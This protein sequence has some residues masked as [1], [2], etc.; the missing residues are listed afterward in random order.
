[1]PAEQQYDALAEQAV[2]ATIFT[3]PE[4][5]DDLHDIIQPSDFFEERNK[6]IFEAAITLQENGKSYDPINLAGALKRQDLINSIGGIGYIT[7]LFSPNSLTQYSSDP[8]GYAEI[9]QDLSRRRQML[10]IAT[11][12]EETA[13]LGSGFTSG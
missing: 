4:M 13:S 3:N 1:M 2:L 7:E 6:I 12:M 10:D 11:S 5:L 8:I 9:V